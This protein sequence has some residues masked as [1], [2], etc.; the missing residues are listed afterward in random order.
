MVILLIEVLASVMMKL[1]VESYARWYSY[2]GSQNE[3]K[4][5]TLITDIFSFVI[6]F[7]YII[8]ISLY[9]TIGKQDIKFALIL[10]YYMSKIFY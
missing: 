9:V 7:N 10:F 3:N 8:P 2:L 4:I 5:F 1:Y 6:L